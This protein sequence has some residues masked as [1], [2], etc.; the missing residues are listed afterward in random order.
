MLRLLRRDRRLVVT[1]GAD[2]GNRQA[3]NSAFGATIRLTPIR[4]GVPAPE[5]DV[6]VL[7]VGDEP[8]QTL[9]GGGPDFICA[10]PEPSGLILGE[11]GGASPVDTQL[12]GSVAAGGCDVPVRGGHKLKSGNADLGTELPNEGEVRIRE[13]RLRPRGGEGVFCCVH[14][15]PR[16]ATRWT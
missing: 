6:S 5:V 9:S 2:A 16:V 13:I 12:T 15:L 3:V 14:R 8:G 10:D 1:A 7:R 11:A 4:T